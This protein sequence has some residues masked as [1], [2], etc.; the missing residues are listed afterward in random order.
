[1]PGLGAEM[2]A[3]AA[4]TPPPRP[5]RT[6]GSP[7]PVTP[8]RRRFGAAVPVSVPVRRGGAGFGAGPARR[9]RFR[10]RFDAPVPGVRC[11]IRW[12][13]SFP[14]APDLRHALVCSWQ[15]RI[16][17]RH[18]LIPDGCV[19]L[20]AIDDGTLVV[21]GPERRSWSFA[22]PPGTR[23]V[24]VRF[25][26]GAAAPALRHGMAEL[27]DRR[28]PLADLVGSSTTRRL[29][30]R[31]ADTAGDPAASRGVLEELVRDLLAGSASEPVARTVADAL[32]RG[33]VTAGVLAEELGVSSR[34]LHRRCTA[35]FGYGPA[36]LARLLRFQRALGLG[37]DGRPRSLAALAAEAGYADQAHLA[38]EC[39]AITGDTPTAVLA[40][41]ADT[42][43]EGFPDR[44][45]GERPGRSAHEHGTRSEPESRVSDRY[46]TGRPGGRK[47][48]A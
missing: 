46:K 17:G 15:A 34:H 39:R 19:D 12:Y 27:L 2:M 23:A 31:L 37:L 29:A 43:V 42:S 32:G 9:C 24:G 44:R 30:Q 22:L 1:M 11:R 13:R 48:S 6:G 45:T 14:P 20:L 21:C 26:P 40:G 4:A 36:T 16:A 5:G 38:R 25:R 10:C 28:V 3:A 18:R 35:A 41:L 7:R 33:A 47:L 8:I